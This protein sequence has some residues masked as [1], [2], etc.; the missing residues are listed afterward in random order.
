L[1]QKLRAQRLALY[2]QYDENL[3]YDDI[4]SPW[5]S[6]YTQQWGQEVVDERNSSFQKLIELNSTEEGAKWMRKEGLKRGVKKVEE[7]ALAGITGN[8]S[9]VQREI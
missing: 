4:A 9:Q 5:R 7:D 8:V 3:T 6:F 2:P 1:T